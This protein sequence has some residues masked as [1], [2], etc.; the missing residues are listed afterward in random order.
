MLI[1]Y[2]YL[3]DLFLFKLGFQTRSG[4]CVSVKFLRMFILG[5][6]LYFGL[7]IWEE[8][9]NVSRTICRAD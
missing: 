4:N 2:I 8:N 1:I 7:L 6:G 9:N 5:I 3:P